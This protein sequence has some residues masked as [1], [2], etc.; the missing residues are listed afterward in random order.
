M[1]GQKKPPCKNEI[2]P[3]IPVDRILTCDRHRQTDTGP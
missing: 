1:T 3:F 2:S